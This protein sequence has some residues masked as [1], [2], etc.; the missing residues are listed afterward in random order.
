M[1]MSGWLAVEILLNMC[2][3]QWLDLTVTLYTC[4]RVDR[5]LSRHWCT[6]YNYSFIS[7]FLLLTESTVLWNCLAFFWLIMSNIILI[8]YEKLA[9]SFA[10]FVTL[11][12][13]GKHNICIMCIIWLSTCWTSLYISSLQLFKDKK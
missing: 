11:I 7:S 9:V 13:F 5:K 2:I 4:Y 12:L 3:S 10:K 1:P 8:E 6:R